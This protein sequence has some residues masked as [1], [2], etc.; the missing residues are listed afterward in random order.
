MP[1]Y[2]M[3]AL[4]FVLFLYCIAYVLIPWELSTGV[5][6]QQQIIIIIINLLFVIC[7]KTCRN[8]SYDLHIRTV[9]ITIHFLSFYSRCIITGS[10]CANTPWLSEKGGSIASTLME[11]TDVSIRRSYCHSDAFRD[12]LSSSQSVVAVSS[13][14]AS[15]TIQP[16]TQKYRQ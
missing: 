5:K 1:S 13:L 12:A 6:K 9:T 3:T 15:E 14:L 4:I 16:P 8:K 10:K 11:W 2:C 7:S